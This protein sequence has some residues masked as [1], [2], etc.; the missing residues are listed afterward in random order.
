MEDAD[1]RAIGTIMAQIQHG[2]DGKYGVSEMEC[3]LKLS[4]GWFVFMD[5]RNASGDR[6]TVPHMTVKARVHKGGT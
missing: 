1:D 3:E 5:I 6:T 4:R 2:L